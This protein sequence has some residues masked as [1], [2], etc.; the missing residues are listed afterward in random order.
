MK[1]QDFFFL[2]AASEAFLTEP[3]PADWEDMDEDGQAAFLV[4]TAACYFENL[5]ADQLYEMIDDHA[6]RFREAVK[7][8]LEVVKQGLVDAAIEA[9]LPSDMNEV[10]L[11]TMAEVGRY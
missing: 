5:S 10:D 1:T 9:E 4:G 3:L 8:T 7:E 11:V 2:Q 6:E